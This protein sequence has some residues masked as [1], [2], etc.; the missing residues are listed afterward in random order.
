MDKKTKKTFRRRVPQAPQFVT[1]SFSL[2][3]AVAKAAERE[4]NARYGGN[5]SAFAT[6]AFSVELDIKPD[7]EFVAQ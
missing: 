2:P 6:H 4:A 7:V 3:I 5:K 1:M